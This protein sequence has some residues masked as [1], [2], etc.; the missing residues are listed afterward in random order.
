MF[1]HIINPV[2][3]GPDSDLFVAQPITFRSLATARD[4][5]GSFAPVRLFSA[6]YPEDQPP[7]V[8]DVF[9]QTPNL[10]RSV[11]DFGSFARTR[12]LPVLADILDR[13]YAASTDAEYLI[14]SNVD[15]A[16]LPHFYAFLRAMVAA[17]HDAIVITRRTL[18]ASYTDP[19]DLTLMYAELGRSHMGYDCFVFRRAVYP[20]YQLGHACLGAA[21]I[22][23][24]MLLNLICHASKFILCKDRHLTFHIGDERSW[25]SWENNE[26]NEHNKQ[27]MAVIMQHY[28]KVLPDR[29]NEYRTV[30]RSNRTTRRRAIYMLESIVARLLR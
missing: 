16:V 19:Q 10:Q 4:F 23:R 26:Y 11:L 2:L 12:K 18:P 27:E 14:Y 7:L 8:P 25:T 22:G 6:Q 17:G 9:H 1:A 5:A 24:L 21:P 28:D 15:I 20:A 3:V 30:V 13:L 29:V